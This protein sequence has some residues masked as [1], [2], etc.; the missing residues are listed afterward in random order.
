M[1]PKEGKGRLEQSGSSSTIDVLAAETGVETGDGIGEAS[2]EG[3]QP[4]MPERGLKRDDRAQSSHGDGRPA[5][6]CGGQNQWL[7]GGLPSGVGGRGCDLQKPDGEEGPGEAASP[8]DDDGDD[9][10][11]PETPSPVKKGDSKES[12]AHTRQRPPFGGALRGIGG[13]APLSGGKQ[14]GL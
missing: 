4:P 8:C 9:V 11:I 10:C 6:G 13:S 1:P 5:T 2:R 14:L 3:V 7:E 12:Q